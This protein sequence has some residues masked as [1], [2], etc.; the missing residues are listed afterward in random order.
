MASPDEPAS[1][2]QLEALRNV[3]LVAANEYPLA[4]VTRAQLRRREDS[5]DEG[6]ACLCAPPPRFAGEESEDEDEPRCDDV[7][8]LNFATYVECNDG[9]PAGRHCRNQR[10]QHPERFP[11]LE[12]FLVRPLA[13]LVVG[14]NVIELTEEGGRRSARATAC[15]RGRTWRRAASSAST[16]ARSSTSGSSQGGSSSCQGCVGKALRVEHVGLTGATGG[17]A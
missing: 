9:C 5:D 7:S 2:E 11:K 17:A 1:F 3:Q 14:V 16:W 4:H 12:P 13:V 15:A 8:C 6:S 10:L